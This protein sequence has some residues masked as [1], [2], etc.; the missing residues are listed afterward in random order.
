[1]KKQHVVVEG[2]YPGKYSLNI[3]NAVKIIWKKP[4]L[5]VLSSFGISY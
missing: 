2:L 1:V 5:P 3:L 4:G